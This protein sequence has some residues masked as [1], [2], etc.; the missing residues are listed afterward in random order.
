MLAPAFQA[1][2][3]R[4]TARVVDVP[5]GLTDRRLVTVRSAEAR[6]TC[7]ASERVA[8]FA[9]HRVA[10]TVVRAQDDDVLRVGEEWARRRVLR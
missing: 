3:C 1:R 5:H 6:R 8:V 9:Q 10:P 4:R 7:S 2:P